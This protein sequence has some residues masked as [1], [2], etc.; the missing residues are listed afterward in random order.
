MMTNKNYFV[1]LAKLSDKRILYDFA[2]EIYF[3]EK[4]LGKKCTMN[5]FL[6]RLLKSPAILASVV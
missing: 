4:A 5:N 6:I 1:G 2:E 3:D